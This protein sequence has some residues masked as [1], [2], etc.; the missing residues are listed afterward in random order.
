MKLSGAQFAA[1]S[2][3]LLDAFDLATLETMVRV[4]LD[5]RL[6]EIAAL[7]SLTAVVHDLIEWAEAEDRVQELIDGACTANPGSA[8]L[9]A[10]Q[11]RSQAEDWFG[12]K[13]A[14]VDV[15]AE[16]ARPAAPA[17]SRPG[18]TADPDLARSLAAGNACA[19]VGA[20][21]SVG[22]GLPGWYD[23]VAELA[24]RI[25]YDL[26]PRQYATGD[27]L[28]DAA[29]AYVNRQGL[30]SLIAFLKERLDTFDKNPTA[31]HRALARLPIFL[32][33][34][35]NYD[36]LLERAYREAG[37]RVEVV[38]TDGNIPFMRR[39]PDV[40]NIVKLYGDLNQ[41]DT[42]VLARQ[43][44][45]SFFLQRP[46][47]VKLLETELA[48]SDVLY[49]GWSHTD[50]HFNLVF[51]ELLTRFGPFM[52]TGYAALFDV[53]EVKAQELRRKHIRLVELPAGADRTAQ[54]AAWLDGLGECLA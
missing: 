21:L 11:A 36:D 20:G 40:V 6:S 25:G 7:G 19:F 51:G 26:P 27:A 30:H 2:Q 29:Q 44:Y 5:R 54:L 41:P 23:L 13:P 1:I 28:V 53:P 14:G 49:L 35:A 33:F 34:T 32:V 17:G 47:M 43:Q 24:G 18:L 38:V 15:V 16:S 48:R 45:E 8:R 31:A 39:G 46:Q 3:A 37:K 42:L 10:L 52:R 12:A 4:Q 22:A 50:P 9:R